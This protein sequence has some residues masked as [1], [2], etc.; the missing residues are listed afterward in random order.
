MI[1]RAA[2]TDTNERE[3]RMIT[4][5]KGTTIRKVKH[6]IS[7]IPIHLQSDSDSAET[8]HFRPAVGAAHLPAAA[9][10]R[11][12]LAAHSPHSGCGKGAFPVRLEDSTWWK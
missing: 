5:H 4:Q 10:A 3:R 1:H 11:R 9:E 2:G 12:C 7:E 6:I 8:R